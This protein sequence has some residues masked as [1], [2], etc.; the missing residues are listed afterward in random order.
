MDNTN[1]KNININK[2]TNNINNNKTANTLNKNNTSNK[3]NKSKLE[4]LSKIQQY[5]I[6]NY[7]K[8][9]LGVIL[10]ILIV[11]GIYLLIKWYKANKSEYTGYSYYGKDLSKPQ[12]HLFELNTLSFEECKQYCIKTP[13]CKGFTLNPAEERCYGTGEGGILRHEPENSELRVWIKP[14]DSIFQAQSELLLTMTDVPHRISNSSLVKPFTPGR[15]NYNF[16][17]FID[18]FKS[19]AW[20]HVFHKGNEITELVDN[21][22]DNITRVVPEQ[23]IGVWIAPFNTFMRIAITTKLGIE[24]IDIENMPINKLSF[25]S[26]SLLENVAEVYINGKLV[27]THILKTQ[28]MFNNGHIY[29]KYN[30]SFNGSLYYLTYTPEYLNHSQILELYKK[31]LPEIR[32]ETIKKYGYKSKD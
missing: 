21:D 32:N 14:T 12:N 9:V 28:G 8:I 4:G 18:N 15:Y 11:I 17:L 25:V 1:K 26:V 3:D 19:D 13:K 10:F 6:D 20:K 30:N 7:K 29:T 22:W 31:T 5:I 23:F 27:K 2:K 16:Y 24:Y